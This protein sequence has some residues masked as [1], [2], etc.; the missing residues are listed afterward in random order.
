M[1]AEA[2]TPVAASLLPLRVTLL[3]AG[4]ALVEFSLLAGALLW[5]VAAATVVASILI[6]RSID[7]R[8]PLVSAA[9]PVVPK[10]VR[11]TAGDQPAVAAASHLPAPQSV[12]EVAAPAVPDRSTSGAVRPSVVCGVDGSAESQTV[13]AVATHLAER[14]GSRLVLAH[15]IDARHVDHVPAGIGAEAVDPRRLSVPTDEHTRAAAA[16]MSRS[17]ETAATDGDAVRGDRRAQARLPGGGARSGDR[18]AAL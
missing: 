9:A 13:A 17:A 1:Y 14:L 4:V 7:R 12:N 10:E 15:L 8:P 18:Q 16:L 2:R 3:F 6:A 5:T 11:A